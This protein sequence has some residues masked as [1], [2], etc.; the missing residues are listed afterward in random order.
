MIPPRCGVLRVLLAAEMPGI[1][2]VSGRP[3][4][5]IGGMVRRGKKA[6]EFWD[7]SQGGSWKV[8]QHTAHP[9]AFFGA[10]TL[11]GGSPCGTHAL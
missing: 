2:P 7:A 5:G 3:L 11:S 8:R 6:I 4:P 1:P 10:R 9:R